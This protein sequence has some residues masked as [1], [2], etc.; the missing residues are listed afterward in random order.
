MM[1]TQAKIPEY[2]TDTRDAIRTYLEDGDPDSDYQEED[3][4]ES[5][6]SLSEDDIEAHKE[7]TRPTRYP[8]FLVIGLGFQDV[9]TLKKFMLYIHVCTSM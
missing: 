2:N 6:V 4:E 3:D 7:N 9:T 5:D 8:H 1:T